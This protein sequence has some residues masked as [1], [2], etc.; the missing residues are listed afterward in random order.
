MDKFGF[1]IQTRSGL[2]VDNLVIQAADQATAETRLKQMY[3]GCTIQ[4]VKVLDSTPMRGDGSDLEG[5]INL[6]AGQDKA[7]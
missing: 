3:L 1:R 4:E 7:G 6:I 5:V 2:V